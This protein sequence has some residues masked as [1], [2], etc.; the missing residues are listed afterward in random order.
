MRGAKA[1]CRER[2]IGRLLDGLMVIFSCPSETVFGGMREKFPICIINICVPSF[3]SRRPADVTQIHN[4]SGAREVAN[5]TNLNSCQ[6]EPR[7]E[8]PRSTNSPCH[9]QVSA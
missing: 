6:R 2:L 4:R 5:R 1:A 3:R 7:K 9:Q 8:C